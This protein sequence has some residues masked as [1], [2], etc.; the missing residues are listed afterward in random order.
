M[1]KERILVV[2]DE[3]GIRSFM[4]RIVQ[5]LNYDHL[6]ASDGEEALQLYMKHG[7]DLIISD[8][9]MPNLD[10]LGLLEQ[11]RMMNPEQV[12]IMVT[13]FD[14][15]DTVKKALKAG[16]YDYINKPLD[17]DEV[18]YSIKRGMEKVR[19][20]KKLKDYQNN[21]EKQVAK[22]TKQIKKVFAGALSAL[23][24]ALE[25][26]DVYTQGHSKRVTALALEIARKM[27]LSPMQV[28]QIKLA[29]MFHDIGKIGIKDNILNKNGSLTPEEFAHIK[30][31]P[32][33]AVDIIGDLIDKEILDIVL[34]HHERYDG[35]GYPA[36]LKGENIPLGARIL[37]VADS[38]DA[39]TSE[40]PYREALPTAVA[41][42]EIKK[43]AGTQFDPQIVDVFL[44][45]ITYEKDTRQPKDQVFHGMLE[46]VN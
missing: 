14:D 28:E 18:I 10:G 44:D 36:G 43:N 26:K 3:P 7:A 19:F 20:L 45:I 2:D 13:A 39:M 11:V 16:A 9:R 8:V 17:L 23:A 46:A 32:Q 30:K 42:E 6:E 21:L 15:S 25:A 1:E 31:H 40:R 5:T 41:I 22:Q 29:G 38:W 12:V 35:G 34:Y 4:S 33:I 27:H 24:N 37:A